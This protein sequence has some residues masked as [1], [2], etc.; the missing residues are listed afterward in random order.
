MFLLVMVLIMAAPMV[1][2]AAVI[3]HGS[4]IGAPPSPK[5]I[6][7]DFQTNAWAAG[8]LGG[9]VCAILSRRFFTMEVGRRT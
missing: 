2:G 1:V 4:M 6:F 7:Q 5:Q 3:L 9:I 8:V